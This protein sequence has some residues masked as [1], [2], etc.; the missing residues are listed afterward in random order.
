MARRTYSARSTTGAIPLFFGLDRLAR[1][2]IVRWRLA[3]QQPTV[4]HGGAALVARAARARENLHARDLLLGVHVAATTRDRGLTILPIDDTTDPA[5][6]AAL[7]EAHF[8]PFLPALPV[9]E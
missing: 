4:R 5:T 3:R 9:V 6:V 1:A 7:V 8:A 2:L